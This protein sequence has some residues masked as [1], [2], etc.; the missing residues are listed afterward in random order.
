M[1]APEKPLHERQASAFYGGLIVI[2]CVAIFALISHAQ[3]ERGEAAGMRRAL[4]IFCGDVG[5][6]APE[7]C[8]RYGWTP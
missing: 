2:V 1:S 6:V 5:E 8:S 3:Y 4:E 7:V